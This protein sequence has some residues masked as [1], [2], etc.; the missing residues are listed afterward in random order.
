MYAAHAALAAAAAFVIASVAPLR[1]RMPLVHV[2]ITAIGV[3]A[4]LVSIGVSGG[5]AVHVHALDGTATAL[6]GVVYLLVGVVAPE[7]ATTT[8]L[9][10]VHALLWSVVTGTFAALAPDVDA[11]IV[12]TRA[13]AAV[14]ASLVA[15]GYSRLA[16][17]ADMSCSELSSRLLP[18]DDTRRLARLEAAAL[19]FVAVALGVLA[20]V[21]HV[22]VSPVLAAGVA[23]SLVVVVVAST[24]A[25]VLAKHGAA[26]AVVAAAL[27]LDPL[28]HSAP[29]APSVVAAHAALAVCFIAA[30]VARV[31]EA[32]TVLT[33]V[34]GVVAGLETLVA[35]PLAD[36]YTIV[37]SYAVAG[38]VGAF[39]G[40]WA[41][42]TG[43]RPRRRSDE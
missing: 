20:L 25:P 7:V 24:C 36:T 26:V 14:A 19:G 11:R 12:W 22:A 8:Y 1:T 13:G 37:V 27:A 17:P 39:L 43:Q 23:V 33:F 41:I 38:S 5:G 3:V 21:R 40:I 42:A 6:V 10:T 18:A 32:F 15:N 4:L 2:I 35:L 28:V 29:M 9:V 34:A 16:A 30:I 31:I